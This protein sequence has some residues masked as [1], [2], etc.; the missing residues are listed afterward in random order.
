MTSSEVNR[1]VQTVVADHGFATGIKSLQSHYDL[2]E[3]ARQR[4]FHFSLVEWGRFWA[5]D[6]LQS[7]DQELELLHRADPHHWSWA[8]RQLSQWRV[9][10][11]DGS[12]TE[13]LRSALQETTEGL[14]QLSH[15]PA[16]TN[17]VP[18]S[19]PTDAERDLAL[20]SFI[21]LVRQRADI[22][23]QIKNARNQDDVI[24]IAQTQGYPIDSLTL[25]RSW[26]QVTDFSKPTWFGWFD[27]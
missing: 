7:T 3:F 17:A 1:F 22:K 2:V 26:S 14:G 20:Q 8:F 5:M 18:S 24:S 11:M 9:L 25:L 21:S 23:E 15:S 13:G 16:S 4:G 10:L 6:C 19:T 27:D 12:V